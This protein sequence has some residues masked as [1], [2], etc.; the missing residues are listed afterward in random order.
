MYENSTLALFD[1][2][3][4]MRGRQEYDLVLFYSL[5]AGYAMSIHFLGAP[6][7]FAG[8]GQDAVPRMGV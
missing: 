2:G 1:F 6:K 8:G 3:D 4:S 5:R 7:R